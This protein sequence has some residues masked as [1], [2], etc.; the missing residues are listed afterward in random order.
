[1]ENLKQ[2]EVVF[3]QELHTYILGDK[4]LKGITGILSKHLFAN[5]FDGIPEAVLKNAAERGSFIHDQCRQADIF[6]ETENLEAKLYLECKAKYEIETLENE[7]LVSD[8]EMYATQIDMIDTNFNLYDIKT[9]SVLDTDYL[10]WQLSIC[11]YLFELQTDLKAGKLF[12]LWLR[13]G[14]AKL[15][16]VNRISNEDIYDLLECDR[17]DILFERRIENL[18]ADVNQALVKLA[19]F[20]GFIALA[21]AELKAT[22]EKIDAL[23]E[24]LLAQMEAN[25]IKKWETEN[26]LVTY[27]APTER[28]SVDSTRLKAE[29]PEVYNEYSKVS[30]VKSSIRIKIK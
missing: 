16:E 4:Y 21:E 8:E 6:G 25:N 2:S 30:E 11:A 18:P 5:K 13:N 28:K 20:E 22:Q 14:Q 1:M 9:T 3:N 19:D 29:K 23:K 24:F 15:V 27:V 12:G 17:A 26:I 7:Y 10:S